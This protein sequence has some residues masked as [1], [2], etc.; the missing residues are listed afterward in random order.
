MLEIGLC[1]LVWMI[2]M[3]FDVVVLCLRYLVVVCIVLSG[4]IVV[5]GGMSCC[6]VSCLR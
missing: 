6:V 4:E 2:Y 1:V 5:F 3:C